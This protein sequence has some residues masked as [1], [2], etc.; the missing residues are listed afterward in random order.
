MRPLVTYR[1]QLLDPCAS[2]ARQTEHLRKL[3]P[4]LVKN[5]QQGGKVQLLQRRELALPHRTLLLETQAI[6]NVLLPPIPAERGQMCR[7]EVGKLCG[8]SLNQPIA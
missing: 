1:L 2:F 8:G 3:V 6:F 7:K 4:V 5:S